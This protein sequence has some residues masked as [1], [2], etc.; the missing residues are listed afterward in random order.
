MKNC[1]NKRV[2]VQTFACM[3]L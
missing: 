1:A 2:G 3:L